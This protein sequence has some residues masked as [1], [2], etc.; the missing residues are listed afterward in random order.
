MGLAVVGHHQGARALSKRRDGVQSI[1]QLDHLV[2]VLAR[3]AWFLHCDKTRN[4]H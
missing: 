3:H 2:A 1:H 4:A